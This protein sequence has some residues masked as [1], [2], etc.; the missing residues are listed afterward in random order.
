MW[1]LRTL[2]SS[3]EQL[4]RSASVLSFIVAGALGGG[5]VFD[6]RQLLQ[7]TLGFQVVLTDHVPSDRRDWIVAVFGAGVLMIV[8]LGGGVVHIGLPGRG[9]TDSVSHLWCQNGNP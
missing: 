8:V 9:C 1:F 3:D 6:Y 5:L 7:H 2:L 4:S